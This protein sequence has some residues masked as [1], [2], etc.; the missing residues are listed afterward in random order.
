MPRV[1]APTILNFLSKCKLFL[2]NKNLKAV[3]AFSLLVL[4]LF[5][6]YLRQNY[7]FTPENI[8]SYLEKNKIIAPI[9]FIALHMLAAALF[10]PCSPLTVMSGFLWGP[11][12]GMLYAVLGA[13]CSSCF[14]F[15]VARYLGSDYFRGKIDYSIIKWLFDQVDKNGWKV[16]AFTQINPIFPA[17]TLGYFYGLSNISFKVYLFTTLLFMLPMS[18]ILVWFGQSIRETLLFGNW[19]NI[20]IPITVM[21]FSFI[22]LFLLKPIMKNL[23]EK[24]G[25]DNE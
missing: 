2:Q 10:I 21:V 12:Y 16:I 24:K 25:M 9:L 19:G 20:V 3:A 23:I 11:L 13:I 1:D 6:W 5:S 18:I 4:I 22:V 14:T 7:Y 8:L 17:S 15:I